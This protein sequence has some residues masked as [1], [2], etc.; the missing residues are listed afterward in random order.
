MFFNPLE[1]SS[2]S[3]N[4]DR[5]GSTLLRETEI[6]LL[7]SLGFD[8]GEQDLLLVSSGQAAYTVIES[9]LLSEVLHSGA[10]VAMSPYIYFEALEQLQRLKHI[11]LHRARSWDPGA[12]I[13][14]VEKEN[15]RVVFM[16]PL[17]NLGTMN[18]LDMRSFAAQLAGRDWS[19]K[20]IVID[21][22]M[23]S[24]GIDVFSVF[25]GPNH[26]N[27]LCYESGSKYLQ[28]GLDLQMSGVV[29][30]RKEFSDKLATARR[31]TGAVMYQSSLCRFPRYDRAI[32][33]SRMATLTRNAELLIAHLT[34]HPVLHGRVEPA[35]PRNWRNLGWHHGGGVVA[36]RMREEGLNNYAWLEALIARLLE[37]CRRANVALTKGVSFGFS[38]TRASSAA[39]MADNMPPFLRFSVGEETQEEMSALSRVIAETIAE[40]VLAGAALQI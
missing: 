9:F 11:R 2:S 7:Q 34:D 3:V 27:V 4:Y 29:V 10:A 5:Y 39:A 6:S 25:D 15:A 30:C 1:N 20:W 16:D 40:L 38:V 37:N 18:T 19:D 28:L 35:Y 21:S 33:L 24:G 17:A 8:A 22:T 23:V 32:Y 26:P 14:L 12:L 13:A 31:N 36:I